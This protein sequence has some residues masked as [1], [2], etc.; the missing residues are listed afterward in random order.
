[1][2]KLTE[3]ELKDRVNKLFEER[4]PV[5]SLWQTLAEHFYPERADFL[6][7]K[8]LGAEL[9]DSMVD[10]TPALIRRDLGNSFSA[11]LRDGDWFEMTADVPFLDNMSER[12]LYSRTQ[13]LRKLFNDRNAG[14]VRATKQGDHDYAA[15]GQCALSVEL[16]SKANGLLIRNWHLRDVVWFEDDAGQVDGVYR[17][18][19]PYAYNLHTK[20]GDRVHGRVKDKLRD[21]PHCIINCVHVVMPADMY[22]D[23]T[24]ANQYPYVSIYMDLDNNHI[25]EEVGLNHKMYVIPRFQ[26]VAG[27]QYAYS[28]ATVVALPDARTLQNMTFTLLEAGERYTRPPLIATQKVIRSDVDLTGDGITWVDDEY[29]EKLGAAL[30]PLQQ[31]RGGFPIGLELRQEIKLTLNEAFYL[32]KLNLPELRDMTAYEVQERLKQHRREVLPLFAPI[33]AEYNGQLCEISFQVAMDAGLLGSPYDIPEQ[34]RGA[35]VVFKFQSP[36]SSSDEELKVN[37][38]RN[39]ASMLAEAAQFDEMAGHNFNMDAALRDAITGMG[40]PP[41]WLVPEQVVMQRRQ[42]EQMVQ[43]AEKKAARR[44]D[45]QQR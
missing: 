24:I 41:H 28:P 25:M 32:S 20:F 6:H 2:A 11:M 30:R 1:M 7:E 33:E 21:D 3:N 27:S 26:T 45:E 31:D 10:S 5:L 36:L 19:S 18:F 29:D 4:H 23:E 13:R 35:D 37:H 22:G 12:W 8:S 15:F 38:F 42:M 9:A 44:D 39:S 43:A 40:A 17:R 14:M 34:L 16:N